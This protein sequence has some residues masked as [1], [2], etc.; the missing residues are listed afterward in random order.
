MSERGTGRQTGRHRDGGGE[1]VWK[2]K[3][4]EVCNIYFFSCLIY[5]YKLSVLACNTE[6]S[7]Q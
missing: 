2:R 4:D 1:G 5:I 7:A 6:Y 3:K